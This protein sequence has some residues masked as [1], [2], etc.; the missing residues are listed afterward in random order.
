MFEVESRILALPELVVDV[1]RVVN[2]DAGE[3]V[4]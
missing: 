2:I 1:E 4:R 3:E